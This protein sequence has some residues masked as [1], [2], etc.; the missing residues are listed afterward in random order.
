MTQS[1]DTYTYV[2]PS[3]DAVQIP[4]ALTAIFSNDVDSYFHTKFPK[5]AVPGTAPAT[6][7][8]VNVTL[9]SFTVTMADPN[10]CVM[11]TNMVVDVQLTKSGQSAIRKT[12]Q[13]G[14]E[15]DAIGICGAAQVSVAVGHVL[16]GNMNK[17]IV[18]LDKF[19]ST[20]GR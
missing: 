3:N 8:H 1:P 18:L 14:N 16:N 9:S 19:V 12:I 13:I 10:L 20:A 15:S 5:T 7:M 6:D 2:W 17:V 4:I 11:D